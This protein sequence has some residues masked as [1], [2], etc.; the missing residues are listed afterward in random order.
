MK[1]A[2]FRLPFVVRTLLIGLAMIV[3]FGWVIHWI[4]PNTFHSFFDGIWWA[5]VT[6]ATVGYGDVVPKTVI[7]KLVAI[8]LIF[9]GTGVLSAY[10]AAL[11]A[12][13][14]TKENA[15]LEGELP[16]TKKGHIVIVGWNERTREILHQVAERQQLISFVIIDET[17]PALPIADKNVHFI[18]GNPSHDSVLQKANITE[19]KMAVI[20]ADPH[21]H[22]A[23]ADMAS[24]LTL[25][26]MK[27]IHPSLYVIVEILTKQQAANATRA[28]ADEIIHT[29]TL[30]S[31]SLVHT[32]ESP[33]FSA[34]LEQFLHPSQES[35]LHLIDAP[36]E[37]IGKTFHESCQMLLGNHVLLLG[38]VR[39]EA[40]FLNPSPDVVIAP[41]DRL[42]VI[43][44]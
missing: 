17:L 42:F 35:R 3:S 29:N 39:G 10:F 40:S 43:K 23:D 21:K 9:A 8:S 16:Y 38:I 15:L 5:I 34:I 25:V 6:A 7:G 14:V 37:M 13:A 2:Y 27:G 36:D 31:F 1:Y 11:S 22:E 32:I 18:K 19:A 26:A 41:R 33:R 30:A 24:I 28:G 4:E 12:A 44:R 20:T